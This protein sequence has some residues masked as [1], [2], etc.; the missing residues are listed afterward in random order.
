MRKT[1]RLSTLTKCIL[2]ATS[3][4]LTAGTA[5][6]ATSGFLQVHD[7]AT[8]KVQWALKEMNNGAASLAQNA[9]HHNIYFSGPFRT[10]KDT[11]SALIK[12]TDLSDYY[13][14]LSSGGTANLTM[15][16]GAK[17][18]FIEAG[19]AGKTTQT[20]ITLDN[21]RLLGVKTGKR[22]DDKPDS[23]PVKTKDYIAGAAIYLDKDDKG[24][25]DLIANNN[26]VINGDIIAASTGKK[27]VT[28]H[29]SIITNGAIKFNGQSENTLSLNDSLFLNGKKDIIDINNARQNRIDINNSIIAGNTRLNSHGNNDVRINRAYIV[30]DMVSG[31]GGA[32]HVDIARSQVQGNIY[33]ATDTIN[34]NASLAIHD[35]SKVKGDIFLY[36]GN[37][38][39]SVA[40]GATL[41][42]N[43]RTYAKAGK[44]QMIVDDHSIFIGKTKNLT[45]TILSNHS[46]IITDDLAN[47]QV[48]LN[49]HALLTAETLKNSTVT[50]DG[51]SQLGI[52]NVEGTNAINVKIDKIYDDEKNAT[53]SLIDMAAVKGTTIHSAFANGKQQ[54]TT[55][56]G[57]YNYEISTAMTYTGQGANGKPTRQQ[58]VRNMQRG[59]LANDV[60]AAIAGLDGARQAATAITG[61][62]ANRINTL[63][64]GNLFYGVREGASLWGDYL[65][66]NANLAGNVDA[67]SA[68]QGM[69]SGVDWTWKSRNGDSVTSGM[70]FGYVRNEL[71]NLNRYGNFNDRISGE[72]YSLYGGWQQA[73]QDNRWSLFANASAS[74]GD[75]RYAT[76]SANVAS[77][78]TNDVRER[79]ASGYK[80]KVFNS[81]LR[82]GIT[83]KASPN[84]VVQPY[85]LIGIN[86]AAADAFENRNLKFANNHS[87]S[88][89]TGVGTRVMGNIAL[90]QVKLMPW[91]DISYR[92]EFNDKT[93][94]NAGDYQSTCGKKR[95]VGAMG[96]GLN[97]AVTQDLNLNSGIY[98]N[99]GDV[100][101]DVSVRLGV[102][103]NF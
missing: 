98:S 12:G 41:Q 90:Q 52:N 84:V 6:A 88:G 14:N 19:N 50:M 100:K 26:T 67:H 91:V 51:S 62:I 16:Q 57:A 54:A 24:E 7:G 55:R 27:N 4:L 74:Y 17:A 60:Q 80:G 45:G 32:T 101:N 29:N 89:Y 44:N 13:V 1:W 95:K 86:K 40:H 2:V 5:A 61:S 69:N 82:A 30:G 47:Q 78:S 36:A 39:L 65:Y 94:F 10:D 9:E 53:R 43:V 11:Q 31:S 63:N 8:S 3:S 97:A 37:S 87:N 22:Y 28:L 42:G 58:L 96:A 46:Q 73:L 49:D 23:A 72:F 71:R 93:Q 38:T 66:Q 83:I 21:A 77:N 25:L 20:R 76:R 70:A 81:E 64:A 59:D 68:L 33:A 18:D 35:N 79:I 75:L 48:T 102:N 56:L 99:V 103:Y 85:A 92:E 15:T 34:N